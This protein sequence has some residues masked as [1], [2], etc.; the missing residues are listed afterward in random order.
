MKDRPVSHSDAP[1]E[2]REAKASAC[3]ANRQRG[4]PG[5]GMSTRPL[6]KTRLNEALNIGKGPHTLPRPLSEA[7][8]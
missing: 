4:R 8:V 5:Q 1:G 6:G 2:V 7:G 3:R